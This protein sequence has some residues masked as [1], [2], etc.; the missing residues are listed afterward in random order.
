MYFCDVADAE[1]VINGDVVK[2][3]KLDQYVGGDISL[4]KL[5]IAVNLLRAI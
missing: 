5:I 1:D 3:R 2:G 4:P